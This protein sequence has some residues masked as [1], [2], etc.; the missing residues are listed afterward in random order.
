MEIQARLTQKELAFKTLYSQYY[1]P[2]CLYAKRFVE[3]LTTREDV[4]SDA[5]MH[6]WEH[7]STEELLSPTILSYLKTSIKNM[8]L[9]HLRHFGYEQD[10]LGKMEKDPIYEITPDSVYSLEELYSMLHETLEKLPSEQRVVFTETVLKGRNHE[11]IAKELDI[12]LKSVTRYKQRV[13]DL[14]RKEFK[15]YL[16]ILLVMLAEKTL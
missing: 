15:D 16:P 14:L 6:A 9:N 12:S 8:C 4:V 13:L 3:P 10:Y 2:L 5:F 7:L 1:A 11:E